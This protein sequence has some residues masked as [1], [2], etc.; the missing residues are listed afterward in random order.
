MKL[1]PAAIN[2][3]TDTKEDNKIREYF[4]QVLI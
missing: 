3:I 2:P 1:Y 4:F